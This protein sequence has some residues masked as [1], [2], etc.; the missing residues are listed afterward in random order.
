MPHRH[1]YAAVDLGSNSFHMLVARRENGELRVIDRIREMVRIAGG[2]DANGRLDEA[3]RSRALECL[4]RF[5]QRLAE[6]PGHQVR[7]VGTQTFRRLKNPQHF[8]VVAETALGCPIDIIS[9]R[10][11]A[12]VV[13]LGVSEGTSFAESPRMVIDIGGGSM[14]CYAYLTR[15]QSH[16]A[17]TCLLPCTE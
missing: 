15:A 4:A 6:I 1:L 14:G 12:R 11:E 8:L 7:A 3:T 10:E 5:G 16:G 13:W 17:K 9:G 2:L